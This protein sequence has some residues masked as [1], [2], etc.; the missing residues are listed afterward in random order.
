MVK[1][2]FEQTFPLYV[3]VE[4]EEGV[5]SDFYEKNKIYGNSV[6]VLLTAEKQEMNIQ[7]EAPADAVKSVKL[8]FASS[9]F[10]G[11]RILGDAWERG[12]GD[13]EWKGISARRFCPW[14]VLAY[15]GTT[16]YCAGVKVRPGALCM[17]QV[18]TEGYTLYLDVRNGGRGVKLGKRVLEAA[19]VLR[20][21]YTDC[22]VYEAGRDFCRSMCTDPI[23][24]E[25]PVYGSNN[26]YYAYGN[27]SE[28][29]ILEDTRYL[30]SLTENLENPPY[31]VL[32]DGWQVM[33]KV[34]GYNGGPWTE[35][36]EKFPDMKGLADKIRKAGAIPGIWFRPLQ[37]DYGDFTEEMRLPCGGL[38]PTHPRVIQ[39]VRED[40]T[41]ICQWG[42]RLI[43][44]DFTT[45]DIFH[46][47]GF[48]MNPLMTS[49]G[50]NFY[51][52]SRT[53]AEI[54]RDLYSVILEAAKPYDTIILGCNTIGHLGAGLMH[55][56]R[57][58]DDTSGKNWER[59]RCIGINTLAF[60]LMQNR[61]F[62][63][64]DADCVGITEKIPWRYNRQWADVVARS[65]TSL[66]LSV[67][68]GI[69]SEIQKEELQIIMKTASK[70]DHH[71]YPVDWVEN[72][73]P[74]I[75]RDGE[76]LCHYHWY[77]KEGAFFR[78]DGE[79]YTTYL[80]CF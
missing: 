62:F 50:W 4:T 34:D 49:D 9:I 78:N 52:R 7:L 40:I 22:L 2:V 27:T 47:W 58:G 57:V 68:P 10:Q 48:Q 63:D 30:L 39:Q 14:Y 31:M 70:Q 43:K 53:S 18:D 60:R 45:Y 46:K 20:Y 33:H 74:E 17:W 35:G 64:I 73:C 13:L 66:F 67:K 41:R 12:Y 24:P 61:T 71:A 65:G 21:V 1:N 44:H 29:D 59:T 42:F 15:K 75:W 77:E 36:N 51:D 28:K 32:D 56:N 38:D 16:L 3:T 55:M 26:W 80:C 5:F 25:K 54:V 23:F 6:K 69:L 79:R 19:S 76:E 37:D 8:R 11:T 72:D